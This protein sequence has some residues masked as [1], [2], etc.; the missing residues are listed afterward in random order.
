M[1]DMNSCKEIERLIDEADRPDLLSFEVTGHLSHCVN[2]K[3]FAGERAALRELLAAGKRVSVPANFDAVLGERLAARKARSVFSWASPALYLR[4][5]AATAGLLVM[6]FAA[7]YSNLFSSSQQAPPP[8][9]G[10]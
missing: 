8:P 9:S 10:I 5:G 6:I 1:T 2:C 4:L 7:E 3:S